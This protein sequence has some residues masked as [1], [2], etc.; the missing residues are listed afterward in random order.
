[1]NLEEFVSVDRRRRRWRPKPIALVI[2]G[3]VLLL[4]VGG[5]AWGIH[6]VTRATAVRPLATAP[7][8]G[9]AT[10]TPGGGAE[11]EPYPITWTVRLD[12]DGDGR[13]I[14]VVDDPAV[15]EAVRRGFLEAWEWAFA[16]TTPHNPADLERYFAPVPEDV[17]DPAFRPDP[18]WWYGLDRA[19]EDLQRESNQGL[20][21]RS[22]LEGGEWSV[23]V[24]HFTTDGSMAVV[25][26][27]YEGSCKVEFY[28]TGTGDLVGEHGGDCLIYVA[29]LVYDTQDG[30]WKIAVL[31]QFRPEGQ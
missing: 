2:I 8:A 22:V 30:R 17:D 12:R 24:T 21:R 29:G 23:E 31:R 28:D 6:T 3:V 11:T 13:L 4:V 25:T 15:V 14:G 10:A 9:A 26:A 7:A 16:S 19:T 5:L 1:M 18:V 27:Q 20:L